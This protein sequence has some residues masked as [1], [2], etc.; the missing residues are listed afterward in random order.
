MSLVE[1]SRDNQRNFFVDNNVVIH[2][3]KKALVHEDKL[4]FDE[5]AESS[6]KEEQ[7]ENDHFHG[8][9]ARAN[10]AESL[11]FAPNEMSDASYPLLHNTMQPATDLI[12]RREKL[13]MRKTKAS[14]RGALE[15]R[16]KNLNAQMKP[17]EAQADK[18]YR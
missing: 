14:F 13:S 3:E 4:V 17:E 15:R 12:R 7:R 5:H 10:R 16:I 11:S 18:A 8:M 1:S 6:K 2:K 9:F